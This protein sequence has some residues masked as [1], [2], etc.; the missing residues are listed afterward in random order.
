M[1][2]FSQI[3]KKE[4]Q[5][6]CWITSLV[7]FTLVVS[8]CS[9]VGI[10]QLDSGIQ[11]KLKMIAVE[12]ISSRNG[13]LYSRELRNL[14]HIGGKTNEKYL[15]TTKISVNSSGTLS[16][17][18]AGSTLKRMTTVAAFTLYDKESGKKL[19]I[20]SVTGDASFGTV[21]SLFGQSKA[22]SHAQERL[23]ILLAQRVVRRLQLYFLDPELYFQ[24]RDEELKIK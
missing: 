21:S 3:C 10:R 6:F 15:L 5:V 22:E 13:Q 14:I 18:G 11:K 17:A 1:W 8:G 23:A 4:I 24:K 20:G 2:S 16:A 12:D 19:L 7:L 9:D